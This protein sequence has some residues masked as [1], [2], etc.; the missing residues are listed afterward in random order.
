MSSAL[1]SLGRW[2]FR[3]RWLVVGLWADVL[4]STEDG[5]QQAGADLEAALPGLLGVHLRLGPVFDE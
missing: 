2:A 5:L 3:A 4:E 1:F